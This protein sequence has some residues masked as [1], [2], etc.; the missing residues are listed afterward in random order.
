[1][2]YAF[3]SMLIPHGMES[4][5]YNISEKNMQDAANALQWHLY[6]GLC[7]NL[8]TNILLINTQIKVLKAIASYMDH[9]SVICLTIGIDSKINSRCEYPTSLMVGM[10]S[11]KLNSTGG[12]QSF[13]HSYTSFFIQKI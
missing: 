13:N 12:E 4:E 2:N 5:L 7:Q 11:R 10:V 3:V 9:I 8:N 1:M 6:N